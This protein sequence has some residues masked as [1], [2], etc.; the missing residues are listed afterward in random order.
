[1]AKE[2]AE[3]KRQLDLAKARVAAAP[4]PAPTSADVP[5]DMASAMHF[6]LQC[7]SRFLPPDQVGFFGACLET[8]QRAV[9]ADSHPVAPAPM[10]VSPSQSM[11]SGSALLVDAVDVSVPTGLEEVSSHEEFPADWAE[12]EHAAEARL[13]S[14]VA[15]PPSG[16]HPS[17][18]ATPARGRTMH[19]PSHTRRGSAPPPLGGRSRSH[20]L[21]RRQARSDVDAFID[22]G[23]KYFSREAERAGLDD[24]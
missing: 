23:M 13:A 6:F 14:S 19:S 18:A 12:R 7:S 17:P 21:V 22:D 3:V 5:P 16:G 15:A 8:I 24:V 20:S 10:D 4:P 2:G 1:M 9:L 11:G